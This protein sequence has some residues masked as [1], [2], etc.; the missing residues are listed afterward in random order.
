MGLTLFRY[1]GG[2]TKLRHNI[3]K[4]LN[5]IFST[6]PHLEYREPFF[7][8]GSIGLEFINKNKP[9]SIWINDKD[10][11]IACLWNSIIK[12]PEQ[13]K[14]MIRDFTPSPECFYLYKNDLTNLSSLSGEKTKE[15]IIEFGFKKLAIHQI[16]YSGLGTKSGG[17]LGGKSQKSKYKINCRWNPH[18]LCKKINNLYQLFRK[19]NI[20]GF[21]CSSVDFEKVIN[22]YSR[23][24]LLYLDPPYYIKGNEL[25][26]FGLNNQDHERLSRLLKNTNHL[27][28]L[29]YDDCPEIRE[30]YKW[31][32]IT[33]IDSVNYSIT[34][35]KN[36]ISGVKQY[37]SKP[38]L[39]IFSPNITQPTTILFN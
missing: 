27:W 36:K 20:H 3:Q 21:G 12:Y 35:T 17:P 34:T 6:R 39:L 18:T 1:P 24:S 15:E 30:L 33:T 37:L 4:S 31:A 16:S 22:D 28:V 32:N 11:G 2:K 10:N 9:E 8:G 19:T 13:L 26:Q 25:Y 29:S 14:Q 23:Q 7:G 5:D 38:E